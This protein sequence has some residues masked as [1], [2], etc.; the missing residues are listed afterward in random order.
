[1]TTCTDCE[2]D[3][4]RYSP[5]CLNCGRRYLA[6]IEAHPM[7]LSARREWWK[8]ALADWQKYGHA[9]SDLRQPANATATQPESLRRTG[10]SRRVARSAK[11]G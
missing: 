1:M 10:R 11:G 8:K 3:L 6:A 7:E 5:A 2:R 4:N 9:E